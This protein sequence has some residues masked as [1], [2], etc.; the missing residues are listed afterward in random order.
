MS[1]ITHAIETTRPR[2]KQ[3]TFCPI[4]NLSL[5]ER[6]CCVLTPKGLELSRQVQQE[7]RPL[8]NGYRPDTIQTSAVQ[9]AAL[10]P[11][12]DPV[13]RELRWGENV[14]KC[15]RRRAPNQETILMAF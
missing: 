5:D 3:R 14:I 13:Q 8:H 2:A 11:T 15:Y 7:S 1:Y 6:T 10:T 4:T 12:W 9:D